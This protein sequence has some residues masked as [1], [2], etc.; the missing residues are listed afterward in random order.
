MWRIDYSFIEDWLAGLDDKT[1]A[2]IFAALEV[3]EENGP[4]LGR[5]LVDT[6]E[7]S[8]YSNMKELRPASSG[9]TV[10]RILFAFDPTRKAIM[11]LGGDKSKGQSNKKKWSGWYKEAIPQ[12]ERIYEQHLRS[13]GEYDEQ[14]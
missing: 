6:L 11:L 5:P 14:S 4:A 8:K 2:H 7:G 9:T 1:V 3:L 13:I 10:V 12:A